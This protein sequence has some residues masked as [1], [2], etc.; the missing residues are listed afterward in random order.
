D[1]PKFVGRRDPP[2]FV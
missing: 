1:A 2:Y